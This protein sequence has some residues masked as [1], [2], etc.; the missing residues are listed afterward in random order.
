ML[1]AARQT[2][3]PG[4]DSDTPNDHIEDRACS[5]RLRAHRALL[6]VTPSWTRARRPPHASA[7]PLHG[8]K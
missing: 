8:G 4:P 5:P 7:V 2:R 1:A 3:T 6:K